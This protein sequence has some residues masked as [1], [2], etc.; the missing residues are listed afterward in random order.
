MGV[1][2]RLR[3]E[4]VAAAL[5][6]E[7][8]FASL[9]GVPMRRVDSDLHAANRIDCFAGRGHCHAMLMIPNVLVHYRFSISL[10]RMTLDQT[11]IILTTKITERTVGMRIDRGSMPHVNASRCRLSYACPSGLLYDAA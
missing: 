5:A 7:T 1:F 10:A 8:K 2:P 9:Q 11:L 4:T 3:L 6:A